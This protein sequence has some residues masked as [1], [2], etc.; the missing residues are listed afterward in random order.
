MPANL[1]YL[2]VNSRYTRIRCKIS[3]KSTM[4]T[5]E[6]IQG[7]SSGVII[8]NFEH[9]SHLFLLFLLLRVSTLL[10]SGYLINHQVTDT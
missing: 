6:Q 3:F 10:F 9:I 8:V 4:K 2:K 1:Y 7:S 5:P